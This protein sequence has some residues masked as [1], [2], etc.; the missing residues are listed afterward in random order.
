ML[1]VAFATSDRATVDQHFGAT[2]G[3]AIYAVDGERAKLV[4]VAEFPEESMDGNENK[5]AD[6]ISALAGC[7]AVYCLA[8]GGSAIR[9]L[10]A[11]GIQPVRMEEETEIESLLV[12]LRR[13]IREGGVTWIDKLVKRESDKARFD[14]MAEEG[15]SE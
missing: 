1:R 8:V 7:A 2:V 9:Q 14:R 12:E 3:F 15:W 10:L 6:K 11:S 4:Q 13:A 5:L